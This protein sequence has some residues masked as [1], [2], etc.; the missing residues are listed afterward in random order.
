LTPDSPSLLVLRQHILYEQME[1][2]KDSLRITC[3]HVI[4]MLKLPNW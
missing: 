4:S 3:V 1:K 2:V